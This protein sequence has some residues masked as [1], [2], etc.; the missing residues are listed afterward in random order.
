MSTARNSRPGFTLVELMVSVAILGILATIAIVAY[1]KYL[2]K[3]H[4]AEAYNILGMIR[5]QQESYRSGFSQY[6]D[7]SSAT[8]DGTS[9]SPASQWPT[10]AP[11]RTAV[12]WNSGAPPEWSSLGIRP[13]GPVYFR[14]DAVAG[15]PGV[16][17]NIHGSNL[18]Y[19]STGNQDA[20]WAAHAYGDLDGNGV[21]S[22]FEAFSQ[23]NVVVV[24]N[25]ND[26]E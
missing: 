23:S 11:G 9:G 18:N 12:D 21:Q 4:V 26:I 22:T 24:L 16:T 25:G 3:A 2:R 8:H 1:G 17:P 15:N 5:T 19:G 13:S 10:S 14:Y 6:C 20:W 7:V